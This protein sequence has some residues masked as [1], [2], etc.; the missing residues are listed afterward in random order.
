MLCHAQ[1]L[2]ALYKVSATESLVL[3]MTQHQRV[4]GIG[5]M[6]PAIAGSGFALHDRRT[7]LPLSV[8][9]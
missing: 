7:A 2:G 5:P 6:A 1:G 3:P 9:P 4:F 8:W